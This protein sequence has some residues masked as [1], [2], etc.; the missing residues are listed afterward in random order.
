MH[1]D[2]DCVRRYAANVEPGTANVVRLFFKSSSVKENMLL[3]LLRNPY[4]VSHTFLL[5]NPYAVNHIFLLRNPYAVSHTFPS[6]YATH[7]L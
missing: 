6:F 7:T 1:T 2:G 4:A 5:R 3:L